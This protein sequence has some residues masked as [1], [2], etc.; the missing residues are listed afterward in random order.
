VL[1]DQLAYDTISKTPEQLWF[2][3][4][5]HDDYSTRN[6]P[7]WQMERLTLLRAA[8]SQWQLREVLYDFWFNHFTSTSTA[9]NSPPPA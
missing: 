4:A 8:Y 7:V 9:G 1:E 2:D 5:R 3:H 6:R